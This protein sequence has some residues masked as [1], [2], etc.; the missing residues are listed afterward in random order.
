M[1]LS[2][3]CEIENE[4]GEFMCDG[5]TQTCWR[6]ECNLKLVWSSFLN[7]KVKYVTLDG[8]DK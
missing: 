1:L 7:E 2:S 8:L 4:T 6:D 3:I 5:D